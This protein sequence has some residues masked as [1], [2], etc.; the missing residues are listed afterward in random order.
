[1]LTH[2][3]HS[4]AL[5]RLVL[6]LEMILMTECSDSIML[7]GINA[8]RNA[9]LRLLKYQ[10]SFPASMRRILWQVALRKLG[11]LSGN[12]TSRVKL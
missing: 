11:E 1:M 3:Q 5:N 8:V 12:I 7:K 2:E 4:R 9:R 6:Q 10:W